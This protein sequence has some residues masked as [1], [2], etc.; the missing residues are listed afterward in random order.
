MTQKNKTV[1]QY[2]AE[3]EALNEQLRIAKTDAKKTVSEFFINQKTLEYIAWKNVSETKKYF[4]VNYPEILLG[5]TWTSI[6]FHEMLANKM[7]L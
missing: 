3:I 6:E 5:K 4:E 1:A 7:G 2:K